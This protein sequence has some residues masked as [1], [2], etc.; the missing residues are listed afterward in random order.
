MENTKNCYK[1]SEITYFPQIYL[2][3]GECLLLVRQL[4]WCWWRGWVD[5]EKILPL[6][7]SKHP[8]T[9]FESTNFQKWWYFAFSKSWWWTSPFG[10]QQLTSFI[11]NSLQTFTTLFIICFLQ[12]ICLNLPNERNFLPPKIKYKRWKLRKLWMWIWFNLKI[13]HKILILSFDRC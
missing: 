7:S 4:C 13:S 9:Q 8:H 3:M 11:V 5:G 2:K 10:Q 6:C 1:F 12:C